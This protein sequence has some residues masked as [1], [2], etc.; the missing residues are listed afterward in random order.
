LATACLE[1]AGAIGLVLAISVLGVAVLDLVVGKPVLSEALALSFPI[2]AGSFTWVLFLASLATVRLH[3]PTM[4]VLGAL[5]LA[6][7]RLLASLASGRQGVEGASGKP[8]AGA[9]HPPVLILIGLVGLAGF[10]AWL[11]IGRSYSGWDDMAIWG[12]KGLG[13]AREGSIWA[14]GHWGEHGLSYPLNIPL[15]VAVFQSTGDLLPVSKLISPLFY[16]SLVAGC[17]TFWMQR[18]VAPLVAGLAALCL[19]ATPMLFEHA[20]LGYANLPYTTYLV[21]GCAELIRGVMDSDSRRQALGSLLLGL[22]AWTRPEGVLVVLAILI[23]LGICAARI[24]A[25][26]GRPLAWILPAAVLA[27][28]WVGF[29]LLNGA[30]GQMAAAGSTAFEAIVRGEYHLGAFLTVARFMGRQ[31]IDL[32]VWGVLGPICGGLILMRARRLGRRSHTDAALLAMALVVVIAGA[33]LQF[34]IADHVGALMTYLGNSGNRMY[35]P[36]A[37]LAALLAVLLCRDRLPAPSK[38]IERR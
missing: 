26:G 14:V 35:L 11:G 15:L 5:L 23:V 38:A 2:G 27:G 13:I 37:V 8:L 31:A 12:V 7:V 10:A 32:A 33:T 9:G 19:A 22:A 1:L 28:G 36:A 21:L 30:G 4:A 20:T 24:A 6:A 29:V 17:M 18:G 34:Y 3:A 25:P 16:L